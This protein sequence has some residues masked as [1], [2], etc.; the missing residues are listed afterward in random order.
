MRL[1]AKNNAETRLADPVG[2]SDTSIVVEDASVLP[3]VPYRLSIGDEIVEVTV[4]DGNT[5]TVDRAVEGTKAFS[6]GEGV[7]V[8]N[9]FTA[10]MYEGIFESMP[11]GDD[12][13]YKELELLNDYGGKVFYKKVGGFIFIYGNPRTQSGGFSETL[14]G[15][16]PEGYKPDID[17]YA[18]V[19]VNIGDRI[20]SINISSV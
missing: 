7:T 16:L 13:E 18:Y 10:G 8:E 11:S 2:E 14:F 9:R 15:V 12:S 6:H 5:L 20:G 4:A 1:N 3:E 17:S 19:P